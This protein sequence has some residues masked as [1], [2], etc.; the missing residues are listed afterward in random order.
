MYE[1]EGEGG[2]VEKGKILFFAIYFSI[3][4]TIFGWFFWRYDIRLAESIHYIYSPDSC[5]AIHESSIA[6]PYHV[7][8]YST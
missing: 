8:G 4:I 6:Q 1:R 2:G 3:A 5:I 7:V